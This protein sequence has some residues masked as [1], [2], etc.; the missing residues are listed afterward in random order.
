L[1]NLNYNSDYRLKVNKSKQ[2]NANKYKVTKTNQN[3]LKPM[4]VITLVKETISIET[5]L[6]YYLG[7]DLSNM[8]GRRTKLICCPF[9]QEKT[10]SF[11][12]T[13][14]L[15]AYN[16]FGCGAQGDVITLVSTLKR[17][18]QARAAFLIAEDFQLLGMASSKV[19]K[20]V[21]EKTIDKELELAFRKREKDMYDFFLNVKNDL[22]ASIKK[23][24]TVDDLER[25]GKIYHLLAD[26]D[27]S[28]DLLMEAQ[29]K[30]AETRAENY[31]SFQEFIKTKIYP[32]YKKQQEKMEKA[33]CLYE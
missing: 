16:C 28:L 30:T 7:I 11:A 5:A 32:I 2:T 23:I 25:Y 31:L 9:H 33:V 22:T 19:R 15:N 13:P 24:K 12:V 6:D 17:V 18:S 29:Q 26:I 4:E 21:K 3:K 8:K 10:G 27:Y 20:V 1:V 14:S